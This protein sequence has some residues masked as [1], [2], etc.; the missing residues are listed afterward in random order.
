MKVSRVFVVFGIVCCLFGRTVTLGSI[1]PLEE[2]AQRLHW[3]EPS[4]LSLVLDLVKYPSNKSVESFQ[5]LYEGKFGH[6]LAQP[7]TRDIK[8]KFIKSPKI[9]DAEYLLSVLSNHENDILLD[10]AKYFV[11]ED[12]EV[13]VMRLSNSVRSKMTSVSIN[14]DLVKEALDDV[15]VNRNFVMHAIGILGDIVLR[16]S[17]WV[18]ANLRHAFRLVGF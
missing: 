8:L 10:Q 9:E 14:I 15:I 17:A 13:Q 2:C 5:P 12:N 4:I 6:K 3:N 1:G 11:V 16:C 7:T 18:N